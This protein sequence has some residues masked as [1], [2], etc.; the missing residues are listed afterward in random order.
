MIFHRFREL[1]QGWAGGRSKGSISMNKSAMMK[2]QNVTKML[3]SFKIIHPPT[4]KSSLY[5]SPKTHSLSL[6]LSL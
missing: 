5:S 3:M 6:S 4:N 1:V 2:F